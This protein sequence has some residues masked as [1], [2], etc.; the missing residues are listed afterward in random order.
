MQV[1]CD[2][3]NYSVF[4]YC[5]HR[6]VKLKSYIVKLL[7]PLTD[8][9]THSHKYL[10]TSLYCTSGSHWQNIDPTYF[11]Y[12][13]SNLQNNFWN[14]WTFLIRS[15]ITGQP[16]KNMATTLCWYLL[17]LVFLLYKLTK[18]IW[19]KIKIYNFVI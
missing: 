18:L 7:I 1:W 5:S 13:I 17:P 11:L 9:L 8:L 10:V 16:L 12:K 3:L 14:Y 15:Y 19:Q 4:V 6:I 2:F